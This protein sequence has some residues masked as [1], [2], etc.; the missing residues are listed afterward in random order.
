[1]SLRIN[2]NMAAMSARRYL[3]VTDANLSRSI[4]RLSSGFRINRAS[5]DPAGLVISE[6]LRTQIMGLGQAIANSTDAVNMIKTAEAALDEVSNQLKSMRT[7]AQHASNTGVTDATAAAA[8]QA[9]ITSSLEALSRISANTMFGSKKLL[10]GSTGVS[11]TSTNTL[12]SVES[13]TA[14]TKS[15]TYAVNISSVATQATAVSTSREVQ[16]LTGGAA[17]GANNLSGQDYGILRFSGARVNGG[18]SYD[19]RVYSSDTAQDVIDR[20]N[21]DSV[22]SRDVTASL[23]ASGKLV[24]RSKY[25]HATN[26]DV[27]VQAFDGSGTTGTSANVET[28]TGIDNAAVVNSTA[29]A[30][31]SSA[32]LATD[33][34]LTLTDVI[35]GKSTTVNLLEGDSLAVAVQKINTAAQNAG[36]RVQVRVEDGGKLRW[37]NTAY[38]DATYASVTVTSNAA[39]DA[40]D[41]M[42]LTSGTGTLTISAD[43]AVANTSYTATEGANV[44]GTINGE[45][46][47]GQ[48]QFLI[49]DA[50][51]AN[52]DGLKLKITASGTDPTGILAQVTIVQGS[53]QFQIGSNA[54]QTASIS[55]QS[56][57]TVKL[58]TTATGLVTS[59]ASLA[60]IDVTSFNGAQD[61]IK[62]IDAAIS[63]ISAQR[64]ALGAFQKNSLE[65]TIN[66]MQVA[67]EN[68]A[69]SE[70]AIRDADVAEEATLFA[71][72]NILIQAGTAMLAQA[73]SSQQAVLQL[74]RA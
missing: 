14:A 9:Q 59:A 39:A 27:Q 64:A 2:Q 28:F 8:D 11:G 23:D 54:G 19:V 37:T 35:T 29:T 57:A 22:L 72:N 3:N 20:I 42:G 69:A 52:V 44:A 50:G 12:V 33:E 74:L 51:T 47:T 10:D 16:Q 6:D 13:G 38:G 24:I 53:A 5:D 49:G 73:N 56:T 61:A 18:T 68:L 4:E 26:N 41:N 63:Q 45:T 58:G 34:T 30:A 65:S 31:D 17:M 46:A 7:L 67:K 43:G 71:R 36:V 60:D 32:L 25:L 40:T 1:M 55:I 66:S 15:G 48:G 21:N 70:S 62:I